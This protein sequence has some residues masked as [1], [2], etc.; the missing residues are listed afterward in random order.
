MIRRRIYF[1]EFIVVLSLGIGLY[2]LN[3]IIVA[4]NS[5]YKYAVELWNYGRE[6]LNVLYPLIITLPFC[7]L[8]YYEK[9]NSF[10]KNV[11]NRIKLKKYL[12]I[13]FFTTTC[14]ASI[15][16]FTI[17]FIGF[18]WAYLVAPTNGTADFEPIMT[19]VFL[20]T[21]QIEN[22]TIYA[23]LLSCWRA[24]LAAQYAAFGFVL[25][26]TVKN[27]FLA[28]SGAFVYS[29]LENFI[30]AILQIPELSICT[31]FYPNRLRKESFTFIDLL[32]GPLLLLLITG[33][34]YIY[35]CKKEKNMLLD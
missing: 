19:N 3:I 4:N 15:S 31:S 33:I 25:T 6:Y 1:I 7:W 5:T 16:M 26:M 27:I 21:Y 34:V 17:S 14:L 8:L 11:F 13:K 29:I 30:T 10:L 20:G 2:C 12:K 28:L 32:A 35:Y 22:Q 24:V 9:N 18:I 23:F